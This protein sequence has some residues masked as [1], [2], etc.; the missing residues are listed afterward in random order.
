MNRLALSEQDQA[1]LSGPR[2]MK[3]PGELAWCWQTISAL[4]SMWKSLDLD[5]E[6]YQRVWKEAEVH[7]LWEKIPPDNPYGTK[8]AM[9]ERLQVGDEEEA[10]A[11]VAAN[12]I[13]ARALNRNGGIRVKR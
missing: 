9:L 8:E 2:D 4:Q 10:R 12:A 13:P 5:Y 1:S 6:R 3:E 7:A 11:R